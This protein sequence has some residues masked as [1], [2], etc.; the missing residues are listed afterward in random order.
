MWFGVC[1][2][3]GLSISEFESRYKRYIT[4]VQEQAT[5]KRKWG[6]GTRLVVDNWG[7]KFV[8]HIFRIAIRLPREPS[9]EFCESLGRISQE[10]TLEKFGS[11][12]KALWLDG[13]EAGQFIDKQW[14]RQYVL[15]HI[16]LSRYITKY[17]DANHSLQLDGTIAPAMSASSTVQIGADAPSVLDG[18][19]SKP[20]ASVD[21]SS[22]ETSSG[23]SCV[24]PEQQLKVLLSAISSGI[25]QNKAVVNIK[26][27]YQAAKKARQQA[28]EIPHVAEADVSGSTAFSPGHLVDMIVEVKTAQEDAAQWT[29]KADELESAAKK[30]AEE[31]KETVDKFA[32][33]M[34]GAIDAAMMD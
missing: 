14:T 12:M 7:V 17:I 33:H 1:E 18:G 29:A 21:T 8:S 25:G 30:K 16:D 28:A 3:L 15:S 24:P 20:D 9:V 11:Q 6:S 32:E 23:S 22:V 26:S 5:W 27:L 19:V 2:G 31:L 4:K 13:W 10:H 34:K